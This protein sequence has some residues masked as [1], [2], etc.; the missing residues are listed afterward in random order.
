[1]DEMKIPKEFVNLTISI[2]MPID[3][4]NRNGMIF[5][6]ECINNICNQEWNIPL[7]ND[8]QNQVIGFSKN[9]PIY[10]NGFL[11]IEGLVWN[12]GFEFML[13]EGD[14]YID[15]NGIRVITNFKPTGYS[16]E[17]KK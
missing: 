2:P 12:N 4:P 13:S 1:M 14:S 16:F 3:E 6:K 9:K 15:E 17:I 8:T 10:S 7:M 11:N 5:T